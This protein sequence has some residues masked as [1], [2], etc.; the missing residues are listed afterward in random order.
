MK[1][2]SHKSSKVTSSPGKENNSNVGAKRKKLKKEHPI[3][4]EASNDALAL[5]ESKSEK[6]KE[7]EE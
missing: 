6:V 2:H 3:E 1:L 5:D 7:E 4:A